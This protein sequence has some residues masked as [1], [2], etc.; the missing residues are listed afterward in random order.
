MQEAPEGGR[1]ELSL[2][3]NRQNVNEKYDPVDSMG[4]RSGGHRGDPVGHQQPHP[5]AIH[6]KENDEYRE[7]SW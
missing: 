5:D 4:G 2:P 6:H 1:D 3:L 7:R